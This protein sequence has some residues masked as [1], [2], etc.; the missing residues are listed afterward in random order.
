MRDAEKEEHER[1]ERELLDLLRD[2]YGV[3]P[4]NLD[5]PPD[6]QA[7]LL[8]RS[9]AA[10]DSAAAIHTSGAD[11]RRPRWRRV[12]TGLTM[13]AAAAV[14]I[15]FVIPWPGAPDR[16]VHAATLPLLAIEDADAS[17][18]PIQGGPPDVELERLAGL[19]D[20]REGVK[21][22]GDVQYSRG[23]SW[24]FSSNDDAG[25]PDTQFYPVETQAYR[26]SDA[27]RVVTSR[28]V[29]M[30]TSGMV[31]ESPTGEP[32]TDET[33]PLDD[34]I[35]SHPEDWPRSPAGLR[36]LILGDDGGCSGTEGFCLAAS[37]QSAGLQLVSDPRL[38]AAMLRALIGTADVEY[39]GP[40]VDRL[41][42]AVE[43]FTVES[44]R[45]D[46][47]LLLLIGA[48]TGSYV[49]DETIL[50]EDDDGLGLDAPALIDFNAVVSREWILTNDVPPPS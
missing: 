12:A 6:E 35:E 37:F 47:Q 18:Y 9:R 16:V 31:V 41:G 49:G 45:G 1:V 46:V 44:P 7:A 5:L 4:A 50:I 40:A 26:T 25:T 39:A 42:R 24:W 28:G 30:D 33:T 2:G 17:E 23:V 14:F 11:V 8:A 15:G 3:E 48:Q 43:V 36:D 13:A 38:D 21:P 27:V 32:E 22:S 19:A 10:F 34:D 29:A 20:S